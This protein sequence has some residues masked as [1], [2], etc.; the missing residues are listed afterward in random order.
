M[1][2]DIRSSSKLEGGPKKKSTMKDALD[3]MAEIQKLEIDF[4]NE[5]TQN[6]MPQ[7][8]ENQDHY[9]SNEL[10]ATTPATQTKFQDTVGSV[11]NP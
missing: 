5:N 9:Q 11:C 4:Y 2:I 6:F 10:V 3:K 7:T 1:N 8:E